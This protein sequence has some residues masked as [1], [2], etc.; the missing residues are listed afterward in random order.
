[1]SRKLVYVG[2]AFMHHKGTHGGY[3]QIRKHVD[4][5]CVV[6]CQSYFEKSQKEYSRISIWGKIYRRVLRT[7]FGVNNIPW[8]LFK[9]IWLGLRHDNLT[10]HYIYGENTFFPWTKIFLRKG[11][12]IVCTFHQPYSFFQTSEKFKKKIQCSDKIIL[13]GNTEVGSF[14]IMTGRDNVVY[15]PHG[16]STDYYCIDGNVKKGKVVLTVGNWLRDY[17]FANSVYH[18]LLEIDSSLEIHI[19]ANP[20]NERFITPSDRIKYMSGITD[21]QLREEYLKSSVLFLPLIRYTA[22]NSLLESSSS[23]CNIVIASDY[24]DNSYIPEQYISIVRMD[25]NSSVNAILAHLN[26]GYNVTLA[27]YID[28]NYSWQ[29]IAAKTEIYL[30]SL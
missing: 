11:N 1:M 3:H 4:Y 14:K 21:D 25:V 20:P 19:V 10:F 23:G 12:V 7:L 2:F 6:D 29:V 5:D 13:V 17:K 16:I 28:K 24:P 15:I 26:L 30:R 9:I 22:N 27:K 18:K 8:F